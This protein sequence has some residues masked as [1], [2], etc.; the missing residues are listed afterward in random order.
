MNGLRR[1]LPPDR[2]S[3]SPCGRAFTLIELLV[4]I[5]IIAILAAMLLPALSKAKVQAQKM[6]CMSNGRQLMYAWIQ[7]TGDNNDRLADNYGIQETQAEIQNKTFRSWVN[8][9][10]SWTTLDYNMT[11]TEGVLH[12]PFGPYVAGQ[13]EIYW[14]PAD[15]FINGLQAKKGMSHR[16]RTFSM[17]CY[18]GAYSPASTDNANEFWTSY[19]QFWKYKSI[20]NPSQLY[21]TLDEHPDS[22]NDGYF[23][24]SANPDPNAV[25]NWNDLP[26]SLHAGGCTFSFADGHSEVHQWFSKICTILPVKKTSGFPAVSFSMDPVNAGRDW[27]WI[28]THSSYLK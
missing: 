4:V 27:N 13:L 12:A 16:P 20:R 15:I 8:N 21:V 3:S 6:K 26:A 7:Y 2:S 23:D 5:A 19:A 24:N 18:M 28:A 9:I 17:S 14:C 22:I 10:M 1:Q 25:G 11:N